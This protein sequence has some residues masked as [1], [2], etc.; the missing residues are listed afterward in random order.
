MKTYNV[1]ASVGDTRYLVSY[2]DGVK[3][4]EDGSPFYD[5]RIFKTSKRASEFINNLKETGYKAI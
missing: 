4:H 3:K 1:Q 5:A 2:H